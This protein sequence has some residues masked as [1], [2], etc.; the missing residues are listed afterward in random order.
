MKPDIVPYDGGWGAFPAGLGFYKWYCNAVDTNTCQKAIAKHALL[1]VGPHNL[2]KD[3]TN[4]G[5][6]NF[7]NDYFCD[8]DKTGTHRKNCIAKIAAALSSG[9]RYYNNFRGKTYQCDLNHCDVEMQC[10][11]YSCVPTEGVSQSTTMMDEIRSYVQV[12][13]RVMGIPR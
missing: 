2:S 8:Q 13:R 1:W 10:Q 6:M 9:D 3:K 12:L 11:F 4:R 7:V 5:I